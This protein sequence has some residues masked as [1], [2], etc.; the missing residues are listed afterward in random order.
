MSGT[1]SWM[2]D[3]T[4]IVLYLYGYYGKGGKCKNVRYKFHY[5]KCKNVRY[6]FHYGK[7]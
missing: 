5:D 7:C 1:T 3:V 4:M 6:K 2:H